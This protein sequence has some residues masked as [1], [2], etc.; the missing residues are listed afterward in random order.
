MEYIHSTYKDNPFLGTVYTEN[1]EGLSDQDEDL[2]RRMALGER[3]KLRE[4]I[5][6]PFLIDIWPDSFDE[7]VYGLDFGYANPIALEEL[8]MKYSP[9]RVP[10]AYQSRAP[11]TRR[12]STV[13]NALKLTGCI[14]YQEIIVLPPC[15]FLEC[16]PE[17]HYPCGRFSVKSVI[18]HINL[19]DPSGQYG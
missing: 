17:N 2:Y 16:Q 8:N 14:L 11:A 12:R 5:Y 4:L 7:K 19:H 3:V 18:S 1:L 6:Q 10:N 9:D 15:S 13:S